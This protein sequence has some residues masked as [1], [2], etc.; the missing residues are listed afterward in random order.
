MR[1]INFILFSLFSHLA[2]NQLFSDL[3]MDDPNLMLVDDILEIIKNEPVSEKSDVGRNFYEDA[4][5]VYNVIN[6][7]ES[8]LEGNS[9]TNEISDTIIDPND[10]FNDMYKSEMDYSST[11]SSPLS[12][13]STPSPTT[14]NSSQGSDNLS[15]DYSS[16]SNQSESSTNMY[17]FV[18]TGSASQNTK[19][20][21]QPRRKQANTNLETPPISP[22]S[23]HNIVTPTATAHTQAFSFIQSA[24]HYA[25]PIPVINHVVANTPDS[26]NPINIIQGTLIPITAVSLSTSQTGSNVFHSNGSQTKKI[27]IQPKPIAIATKPNAPIT[28]STIPS[29]TPKRVV[30]SSNDY[31]N[32]VLKCK[33]QQH[34]VTSTSFG[35]VVGTKTDT[36][37]AVQAND[38]NV[39]KLISPNVKPIAHA[40]IPTAMK[41]NHTSVPM[42]ASPSNNSFQIGL[43]NN[44]EELKF[45]S[46]KQDEVDERTLKK[47][48]RMIK[49]RESACQSRKKKKE[50]VNTL[51]ARLM[52]LSKENHELK[53]VSIVKDLAFFYYL[54]SFIPFFPRINRRTVC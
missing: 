13:R 4:T 8:N 5:N 43:P 26:A 6:K 1:F 9:I 3:T 23:D 51:E 30:L 45:K 48:M 39:L 21:S 17:K 7:T 27:K 40:N 47:Q 25:Q 15:V 14:S 18:R 11:F 32:L 53:S 22:P 36:T 52:N 29:S 16:A 49:N 33:A 34:V 12:F 41:L 20:P 46:F 54:F 37:S 2:D 19:I 44:N 35:T 42:A 24:P 50:Y 31:K 38:S 10:F 28:S